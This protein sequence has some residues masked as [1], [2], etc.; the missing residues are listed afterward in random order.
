MDT[1][2]RNASN[3]ISKDFYM[4]I[5]G[6]TGWKKNNL[7]MPNIITNLMIISSQSSFPHVIFL[8]PS[9]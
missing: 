1:D 8:K 3:L 7:T 4:V 2:W 6:A 5:E 9:T